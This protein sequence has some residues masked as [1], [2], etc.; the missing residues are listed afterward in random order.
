MRN[1]INLA[2]DDSEMKKI[3]SEQGLIPA[4]ST[5]QELNKIIKDDM[6][7]HKKL[8]SRIGLEKQ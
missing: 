7:F 6:D 2:L 5:S 4:F 3:F 8:V 1:E